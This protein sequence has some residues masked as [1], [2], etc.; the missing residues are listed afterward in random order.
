MEALNPFDI[1]FMNFDTI[2]Y[3]TLKN[4]KILMIDNSAPIKNIK[5]LEEKKILK[6]K[7]DDSL[8]SSFKEEKSKSKNNSKTIETN[9]KTNIKFS[10]GSSK[11]DDS[12]KSTKKKEKSFSIS[13][14]SKDSRKTENFFNFEKI[15]NN[16]FNVNCKNCDE[17]AKSNKNMSIKKLLFQ[18]NIQDNNINDENKENK[19]KINYTKNIPLSNDLKKNNT[20]TLQKTKFSATKSSICENG[21]INPYSNTSSNFNS[22]SNN[23]LQNE[24]NI[25]NYKVFKSNKNIKPHRNF[26]SRKKMFNNNLLNYKQD[27]NDQSQDKDIGKNEIHRSQTARS[28]HHKKKLKDK[29]SVNVV[30]SLNICA[31]EPSNINLVGQFNNLVDKIN[32]QR[33]KSKK[34]KKKIDKKYEM[35]KSFSRNTLLINGINLRS[36]R[37]INLMNISKSSL[38]NN[39]NIN[40]NQNETLRTKYL[41]IN[42][43]K[44]KTSMPGFFDLI[45]PSNNI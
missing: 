10:K 44:F 26:S 36:N 6:N 39:K 22:I 31:E 40:N 33:S 32:D 12:I 2:S 11:K 16:R 18:N 14:N 38:I 27:N 21:N 4:G 25:K 30:C 17:L 23:Q 42:K 13:N 20:F 5:Q 15:N 9:C 45:F 34:D 24:K 19:N 8:K 37:G 1:Q 35:Y 7:K 41:Q 29:N 28:I 43:Q 3:I